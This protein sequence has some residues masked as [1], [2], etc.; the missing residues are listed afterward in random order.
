M[1]DLSVAALIAAEKKPGITPE[2]MAEDLARAEAEADAIGRYE[3]AED[4][5]R[6]LAE[7]V[8]E[9]FADALV[10]AHIITDDEAT[11]FYYASPKRYEELSR[12][13]RAILRAWIE[14]TFE[15]SSEEHWRDSYALKHDFERSRLGFYACEGQF[16]GAMREA[17]YEPSSVGDFPTFG[18]RFKL[19]RPAEDAKWL[20]I[21]LREELDIGPPVSDEEHDSLCW[22]A[23][24]VLD[25]PDTRAWLESARECGAGTDEFVPSVVRLFR[26][27][28]VERVE[29]GWKT[30]EESDCE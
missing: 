12:E 19:R 18:W 9:G 1:R 25:V 14:D 5:D 13:Q 22:Y 26:A 11:N 2:G 6:I 8:D 17:G 24:A 20:E 21:E 15:P 27:G 29:G 30:R 3:R 7:L 16:K 4:E 28:R 10:R 23:L